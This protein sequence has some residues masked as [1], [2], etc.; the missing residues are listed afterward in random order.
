MCEKRTGAFRKV[1]VSQIHEDR[2]SYLSFAALLLW[3]F[4][5]F[6]SDILIPADTARGLSLL[7]I[8]ALWLGAEAATLSV[9]FV[10]VSQKRL[11]F[12]HDIIIVVAA[13]VTLFVGTL[14]VLYWS[15]REGSAAL[16]V[17]GV[18]VGAPGSAILLYRIGLHF[19]HKGPQ[20]LLVNVALALLVVSLTDTLMLLLPS[21]LRYLALALIPLLVGLF[22]IASLRQR[23]RETSAR[24]EDTPAQPTGIPRRDTLIRAIALPLIVGLAYGLMQ[25]LTEGPSSAWGM[26]SGLNVLSFF[27]S[28]LLIIAVAAFFESTGLIKLLCFIAVPAVGLAY[29]LL[30][31]FPSSFIAAQ[32]ICIIGFNSFYFMVWALFADQ[33]SRPLPERRFLLGL[34]ILVLSE[35]LGSLI[36]TRTLA[37]FS[38]LQGQATAIVSLVVVYLLLMAG[39]L[40][41]DRSL[42]ATTATSPSDGTNADETPTQPEPSM[43]DLMSLIRHYGLSSR[44]KDVF[45]LL[46]RGRNRVN[47]SKAL[48]ISDNTTRTHMRNIYR[49]LGVHSQQAL[50][51]LLETYRQHR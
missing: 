18:L 2:F 1:L 50:L 40:S 33:Q 6:W 51:D 46:A 39:I 29:V 27:I 26:S 13:T 9:V 20:R 15:L 44:E 17:V 7:H 14:I 30:P 47:I 35:A 3:M 34:L 45:L 36:G 31:L 10:L 38:S 21:P 12:E 5:L 37:I 8:R 43:K 16:Q 25:R 11:R 4:A 22:M 24:P 32:S 23:E 48:F 28:A 19:A 42:T 41:F 49:K